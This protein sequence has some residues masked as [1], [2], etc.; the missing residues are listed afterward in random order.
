MATTRL[1]TVEDLWELEDDGCRHELIRGELLSMAPTGGVHGEL[2]Y[3]IVM[4]MASQQV[5]EQGRV[6][7]GDTGFRIS[8]EE[9]TVLAPDI[10]IVREERLPDDKRIRGFI[11]VV[12]DLVVEILS[13][14]DRI[15]R[16]NEKVALYQEGGVKLIWLVDPDRRTVTEY[17]AEKPVRL[18]QAGDSLSADE[19]FP[20]LLLRVDEIFQI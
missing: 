8:Q 5:H 13:P 10:A 2:L 7:V 18:L 14:S 9:E 4:L 16:I 12:P 17:A 19:L 3:R 1:L 11:P 15:G 6:F 20:E